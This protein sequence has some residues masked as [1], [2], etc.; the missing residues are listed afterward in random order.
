MTNRA[1]EVTN[2]AL[3]VTREALGMTS[4]ALGI[5]HEALGMTHKNSCGPPS[6]PISYCDVHRNLACMQETA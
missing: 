4:D 3:G 1:L 5:T 6:I 2:E